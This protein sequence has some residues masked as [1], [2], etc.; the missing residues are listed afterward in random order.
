MD[1]DTLRDDFLGRAIFLTKDRDGANLVHKVMALCEDVS[2][3][4]FFHSNL[5]PKAKQP[6]ALL[7]SIR[8]SLSYNESLTS[9]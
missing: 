8:I 5:L 7:F 3:L 2:F 6:F 9:Y 4:S 1:K